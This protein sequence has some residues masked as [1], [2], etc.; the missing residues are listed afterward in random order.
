[1]GTRIH[2]RDILRPAPRTH[3]AGRPFIA[4]STRHLIEARQP[5][6]KAEESAL[7]DAIGEQMIDPYTI[8]VHSPNKKLFFTTFHLLYARPVEHCSV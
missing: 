7:P 6:G 5:L 4:H 1:M 3:P 8:S 2:G